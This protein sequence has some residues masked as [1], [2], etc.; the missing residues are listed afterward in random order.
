[1]FTPLL[2]LSLLGFCFTAC[3]SSW[4]HAQAQPATTQG[5]QPGDLVAICGDSITEQQ[6]YSVLMEDYLLMCQPQPKLRAMQFGW[7]G[8]TAGGF[9]QKMLIDVAPFHPTVATTCY[10][11]NDGGY[12]PTDQNRLN[13]YRDAMTG[14]VE[15]FKKGGVRFIVVGTPGVVDTENFIRPPPTATADVYNKTLAALGEVG[16]EVAAKEGVGFADVHSVMMDAMTQ[17]EAKYAPNYH[18]AD[19][20]VHPF[21]NGHVVMAYAFLKAL[22]CDGNIGTIT[23]DLGSN[24]ATATEGHKILS[25][26]SGAVKLESVKYPFCFT[27][28]PADPMSTTGIIQFIPFNQDLNRYMLVVKNASSKML[29]VTWGKQSKNY[30]AQDLEKGVN[31][32]AEFLDNPF[33]QPFAAVEAK[34]QE[35]QK[36][37]ELG[38]KNLLYPLSDWEQAMPEQSENIFQM[39]EAVLKK[40]K[41]FLAASQA[42]VVPVQHTIKVEAVQ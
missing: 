41:S 13:Q 14:I 12:A 10:G 30:S 6:R 21:F 15:N 20:G 1:M 35:Q 16:K 2:R 29:K 11:M 25:V 33:S 38:V 9:L 34:I 36:F 8:E 28:D 27:G 23:L 3:G 5:L 17:A 4:L 32:A 31:L 19:D 40:A 18:F 22:G 24:T 26:S 39:K 7:N 42:G 37:E